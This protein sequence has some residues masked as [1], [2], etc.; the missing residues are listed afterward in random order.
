MADDLPSFSAR[1]HHLDFL[2]LSGS[3]QGWLQEAEGQGGESRCD[4]LDRAEV[5]K[6]TYACVGD[7]ACLA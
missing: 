7:D 4:G 1:H 3:S 5:G 6:Q 2:G